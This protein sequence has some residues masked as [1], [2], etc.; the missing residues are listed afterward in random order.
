MGAIAAHATIAVVLLLIVMLL[1]R[2]RRCWI[3]DPMA[4]LL[5]RILIDDEELK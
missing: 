2:Q 4:R 1:Y 3:L 5:S